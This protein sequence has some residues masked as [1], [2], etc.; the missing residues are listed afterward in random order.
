[1]YELKINNNK[2]KEKIKVKAQKPG[3]G[4]TPHLSTP[5]FL[6]PDYPPKILIILDTKLSW[7]QKTVTKIYKIENMA[8]ILN[9]K[10]LTKVINNKQ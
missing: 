3:T 2:Q 6:K 9:N 7:E 8:H 4:S 10:S 5:H 1:M